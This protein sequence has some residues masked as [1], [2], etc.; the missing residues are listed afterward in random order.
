[1]KF[2]LSKKLQSRKLWVAVLAALVVFANRY[3]DLGLSETDIN[4]IVFALVSYI[5]AEG[6]ADAVARL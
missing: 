2:K 6:T 1:M 5:V 3:F 4:K